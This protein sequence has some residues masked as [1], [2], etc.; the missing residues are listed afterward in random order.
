ML[1]RVLKYPSE[2][3]FVSFSCSEILFAGV[4]LS[5][6]DVSVRQSLCLIMK[7]TVH[8][9]FQNNLFA[10]NWNEDRWIY[11]CDGTYG[12]PYRNIQSIQKSLFNLDTWIN[13]LVNKYISDMSLYWN[14][15]YKIHYFISLSVVLFLYTKY[16]KYT[17]IPYTPG[18]MWK[19]SFS[20]F[21]QKHK[22]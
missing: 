15:L 18:G 10:Y 12:F 20:W 16:P 11:I 7:Q 9:L 2:E 3:Q 19:G 21:L 22:I 14:V 17:D 13:I 4:W 1:L 8:T 5:E 6:S